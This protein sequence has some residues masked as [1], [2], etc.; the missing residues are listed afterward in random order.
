MCIVSGRVTDMSNEKTPTN[1]D[2]EP[3]KDALQ[4]G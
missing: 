4:Q 2:I 3:V 1:K